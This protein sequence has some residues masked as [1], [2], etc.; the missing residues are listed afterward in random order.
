MT[1]IYCYR[2]TINGKRYVGQA[3]DLARRKKEHFTRA[4]N[5]FVSNT[6]YDSLI[7]RAFRKYGYENFEYMVLEECL[8]CELDEKEKYWIDFY[9]TMTEGYN[10][11]L[12]GSEKH[13]CK[14][15][16]DTLDSIQDDLANTSMI[17]QDIADKHGVS[18]GFVSDFNRGNIWKRDD[19]VYP[20]R[21]P[22]KKEKPQYFCSECGMPITTNRGTGLCSACVQKSRRKVGRPTREELKEQ[23]RNTSFVELGNFYGVSDN[24][25]KKWCKGYNLP[26]RKKDIKAYSDTE[27]QN[28]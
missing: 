2:N 15:S 13:F 1:G 6:E 25:I 22:Y 8:V 3:T 23:I 4:H 10:L 16:Q 28:I 12:G 19:I 5:N 20:I 26:S 7:H 9:H 21:P 17:L 18:I 11:S 14:L 27:W 24:A